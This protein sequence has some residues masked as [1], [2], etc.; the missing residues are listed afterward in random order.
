MKFPL[1]YNINTLSSRQVM[2]IPKNRHQLRVTALVEDQILITNT[3]RN[4]WKSLRRTH[5]HILGVK[6]LT[7]LK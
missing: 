6:G 1:V 4:V 7:K 2:R 5:I 3:K